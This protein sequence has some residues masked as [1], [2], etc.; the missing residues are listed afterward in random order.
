MT[1]TVL[2]T[3]YAWESLDIERA[4]LAD[5]DARL[6]V[7]ETGAEDEL[8][9][10]APRA[11]AILTCWRP[12]T[13]AVLDAAGHCR[14]VAR[15]GVGLDNI[16]VS[17]ATELG[18]VVTNVPDYCV[19]EVSDHTAALVLALTRHVVSFAG[20]VRS[21]GWDNTAFGP[22]RRLSGQTVGLVGAGAIARRVADKLGGLGMTVLV[23]SPS[24]P[25]GRAVGLATAVG[26]LAELLTRSDVVSLHVPLS[27]GTRH[28]I[29]AD[30][31]ARMK[32]SALLVNTSRGPVVDTAA[33]AAALR[34][35]RLAGAG[36]DVL[37]Q[38]PPASD[39][40]LLGLDNV[41]L[42]PH[43][44]F[45]SVEAVTELQT[46]AAENVAAVLRGVRPK[47]LVNAGV[48]ERAEVRA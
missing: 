23:W 29:D 10:L 20:Q 14:T 8:I 2:I 34:E 27:E 4:I 38:E 3:A 39:D 42:T 11:D 48:Y 37:P 16:D 7:A 46:K 43:A 25:A 31:L 15:Y 21:G 28:L 36:L 9:A 26:S 5:A 17:R 32:P 19:E 41:I 13:R 12:V 6:L 30:A 22:M 18:I 1:A 47:Y 45:A 40:P 35:G 44:A 33:L 24:T